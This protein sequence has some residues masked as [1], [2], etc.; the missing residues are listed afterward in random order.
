MWEPQVTSVD[1]AD[2]CQIGPLQLQVPRDSAQQGQ[3]SLVD[4]SLCRRPAG[5]LGIYHLPYLQTTG[6][7]VRGAPLLIPNWKPHLP[8]DCSATSCPTTPI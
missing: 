2:A 3:L 5:G 8:G 7:L 1:A 4:A 6:V